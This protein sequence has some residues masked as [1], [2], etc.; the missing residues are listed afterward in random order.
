MVPSKTQGENEARDAPGTREMNETPRIQFQRVMVVMA[1]PDDAEFTCGGTLCLWAAQGAQICYVVCSDGSRGM[2][3]SSISPKE[4]AILRQDEQRTA[5]DV[6]GVKEIIFLGYPDGE[7]AGAGDL[8]KDLTLCLRSFR[9][10][11]LLTFDPWRRYQI[12]PDHRAVGF[13]SLDAVVAAGNPRYFT[14]QPMQGAET[15]RVETV[16]LLATDNPD[17]FVNITATFQQKLAAI[18]CHHS[19]LDKSPD[20]AA[21]IRDCN[22]DYG[23]RAGSTY[24][25][26]FKVLHPFCEI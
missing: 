18:T 22:R 12:H 24:A 2:G 11:I 15:H 5:A 16:Y 6:V 21:Q 25:E 9:P 14:D 3:A 23:R 4:L 13:C 26:A 19:Q 10:E 8:K 17:V 20:S 7:L 1:H